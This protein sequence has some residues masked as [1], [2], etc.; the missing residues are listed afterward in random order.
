MSN[1]DIKNKLFREIDAI[2][3]QFLPGLEECIHNYMISIP[4]KKKRIRKF[5]LMKGLVV[6]IS[7]DFNA[8]L[9]DFEAYM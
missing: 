8:P 5:G 3:E 9:S 4:I 6:R 1:A 2:P 7:N